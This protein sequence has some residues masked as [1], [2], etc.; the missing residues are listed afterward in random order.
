MTTSKDNNMTIKF[1]DGQSVAIIHANTGKVLA[2]AKVDK[3][4]SKE[5]RTHTPWAQLENTHEYAR[6]FWRATEPFTELRIPL[7]KK[8]TRLCIRPATDED[9]AVAQQRADARA[10]RQRLP[11]ARLDLQ[12]TRKRL[13]ALEKMVKDV[14]EGHDRLV[15]AVER[16]EQLIAKTDTD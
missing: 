2:V 3:I 10:A 9:R 7:E 16:D 12:E 15:E 14:R 5:I 8:K 4:T 11:L 1:Y 6:R 13:E